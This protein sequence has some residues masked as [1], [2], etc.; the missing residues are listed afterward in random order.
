MK[1]QQKFI[2]PV[3]YFNVLYKSFTVAGKFCVQRTTQD[4]PYV[5]KKTDLE[6]KRIF[7]TFKFVVVGAAV[8]VALPLSLPLPNKLNSED[9][10]TITTSTTMDKTACTSTDNLTIVDTHHN[11]AARRRKEEI[12]RSHVGGCNRH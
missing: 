5:T 11:G 9:E 6:A 1:C 12:R 4:Q 3:L 8:S 7:I 2:V 10:I